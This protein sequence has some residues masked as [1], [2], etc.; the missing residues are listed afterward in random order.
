MFHATVHLF[1][2]FV[3]VY[4][5]CAMTRDSL[6]SCR[7]HVPRRGADFKRNSSAL[8]IDEGY[9]FVDRLEVSRT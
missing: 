3:R 2:I 5:L 1:Y 8:D 9:Y 4:R 7:E 6:W